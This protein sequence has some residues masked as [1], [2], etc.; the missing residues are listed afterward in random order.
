MNS[1]DATSIEGYVLEVM[2]A[3]GAGKSTIART[4]IRSI[5]NLV[6]GTRVA[7]HH[8]W[9][10][11]QCGAVRHLF[12]ARRHQACGWLRRWTDAKNYAYLDAFRRVVLD[13]SAA[14]GHSIVFDHG[15]LYRLAQLRRGTNGGAG[16]VDGSRRWHAA[17]R[18]W[19][20]TL[21]LVILLD[22]PDNVLIDRV[23]ARSNHHRMKEMRRS[24][25]KRFAEESR[26]GLLQVKQQ[27]AA[28]GAGR[29][30]IFDTSQ[31]TV[32]EVVAAVI[33]ECQAVRKHSHAPEEAA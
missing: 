15:P 18:Y 4:L 29:T 13:Q 33:S 25:A 19:S 7:R 10:R 31:C 24:E 22:A 32:D 12:L 27:V 16:G 14:D 11:T 17:A 2:G 6:D 20:A 1:R 5:A 21:D 28:L 26:S 23:L 8:Y 3:A 9:I 30:L